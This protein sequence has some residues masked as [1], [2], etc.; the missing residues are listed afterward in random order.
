MNSFQLETKVGSLLYAAIIVLA[1]FFRFIHL[2]SLPLTDEE[3][4]SALRAAQGTSTA[5]DFY[6]DSDIVMTQPSYEVLTRLGF[7]IFEANDFLARFFPALAGSALVL[8]PLLAR[9]KL[10]WGHI[11]LMGFLLAIC[12]V[13]VTISRT[14]SGAS[15][16]S[17]GAMTFIMA[18]LGLEE[19]NKSRYQI[20]AGIGLG[21]CLASGPFILTGILALGIGLVIW[22]LLNI[23][24]HKAFQLDLLPWSSL[25][26]ILWIAAV[27]IFA[28]ATGMGLFLDGIAGVFEATAYWLRGWGFRSPYAST[29]LLIMIPI[30]MPLLFFM[31]ILG[32]WTAFR[33]QD[34]DKLLA[35]LFVIVGIIYVLIY[36]GRQP[37]DLIW[38]ALPLA[39][40]GSGYLATRSRYFFEGRINLW[41]IAVT[42]LIILFAFMLYL[43]LSSTASQAQIIDPMVSLLT[44]LVFLVVVVLVII[45][46]GLGW[47][48]FSA[49]F[50]VLLA[51]LA[52]TIILSISSLWRLNF[53]SQVSKANELW[54][55]RVPSVGMGLM[56]ETI[57][58]TSQAVKGEDHALQVEILGK[59]PY[60][61]IWALRDFDAFKGLPDGENTGSP[62]VLVSKPENDLALQDD[63]I[64]QTMVIAEEWGWDSDLPP[65]LLKWGIKRQA[66]TLFDEWLILVRQDLA[67]LDEE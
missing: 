22:R 63:Y 3:S 36:P 38:I 47:D 57:K 18:I 39:F 51:L 11:T 65:S 56:I 46:F 67:S 10:G 31:G 27:V 43:Q 55:N 20:M 17:F 44:L 48:W 8:T 50:S 13:F 54:R 24:N 42:S 21:L 9:R 45:F 14:A 6:A 60:A 49:R 29:A 62:L 53:N 30:Y 2:G 5:S 1:I 35:F 28:V 40:L 7:E 15:L 52:L 25:R 58:T 12:P 66:P 26:Q 41:V 16:S 19:A 32:S 33:K 64:G 61:L 4:L 37:Y 59:A 34:K 23:Q